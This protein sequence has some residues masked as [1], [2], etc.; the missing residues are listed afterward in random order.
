MKPKQSKATLQDIIYDV[1][2]LSMQGLH[3][4][5]IFSA[6]ISNGFSEKRAETI[7]F[8]GQQKVA[9]GINNGV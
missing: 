4:S 5:L 3:P 7:V 1:Y 6:L 8:W 9:K 2:D